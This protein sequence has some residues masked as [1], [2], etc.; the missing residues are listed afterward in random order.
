MRKWEYKV[1]DLIKE[2]EKERAETER[3]GHW[4]HA[5]D[6]EEVLNRLGTQ[7]WELVGIHFILEKQEAVVVGFFKVPFSLIHHAPRISLFE[8]MKYL[9]VTYLNSH[10]QKTLKL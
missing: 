8:S 2:I 10:S 9:N 5:S 6:L 1:V 3:S 7:G 4:L